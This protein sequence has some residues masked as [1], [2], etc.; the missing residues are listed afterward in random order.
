MAR[1]LNKK[2]IALIVGVPIACGAMGGG[3]Y[4]A[5]KMH[6]FQPSVATLEKN[7]DA[8]WASGDY[9]A[10]QDQYGRAA[11]RALTNIPLQIKFVDACDYCVN[12]DSDKYQQL[13][14][15]YAMIHSQDLRNVEVLRR[16][17]KMQISDVKNRTG[18]QAN[19]VALQQ[20][21]NNILA[22]IPNDR[23]ARKA[24]LIAVIEPMQRQ[25]VLKSDADRDAAFIDVDKL[26]EEDPNDGEIIFLK[27]RFLM[28]Q[29]SAAAMS[30][31][32]QQFKDMLE[33][34]RKFVDSAVAKSPENADAQFAAYHVYRAVWRTLAMENRENKDPNSEKRQ[35][36]VKLTMMADGFLEKAD[37]FAKPTMLQE[38]FINIRT[39]YIRVIELHDRKRADERYKQLLEE[40]PN[41][42]IPRIL[43]AKFLAQNPETI[44]E[45]ITLL[46]KPYKP[47]GPVKAIESMEL[48]GQEILET[49][50]LQV[51]RLTSLEVLNEESKR[52]AR[53]KEVE[54]AFSMLK[55][56]PNM[57]QVWMRRIEAGIAMQHDRV[58]DAVKNL[59]DALSLLSPDSPSSP[60]VELYN[61]ILIEDAIAQIRLG[62][63]GKARPRLIE[64]VRRD[65]LNIRAQV[66]LLDIYLRE[67]DAKAAQDQFNQLKVMIPRSP[68]ISQYEPMVLAL[69]PDQLEDKYKSMKEDTRENKVTKLRLAATIGGTRV[70]D[71]VRIGRELVAADPKDE[72][73]VRLLFGVLLVG[74][75]DR[76]A[77]KSVLDEAI[78]A[79]PT[80]TKI[81]DYRKQMDMAPDEQLKYMDQKFDEV[82]DPF[83]RAMLKATLYRDRNEFDKAIESAKE[84]QKL[85]PESVEALDA[86]FSTLVKMKKYSEADEM[87]ERFDKLGGD[88]AGNELRKIRLLVAKSNDQNSPE[89]R[90]A[91][92]AEATKMSG[93]AAQKY[94]NI[95]AVSL[96][97][98]Q[99]L[100]TSLQFNE[101]AEQYQQTLNSSPTNMEAVTGLIRCLV[102]ANRTQE[103]SKN[104]EDAIR[105]FPGNK[106][107]R[108]LKQDY[109][110]SFGDPEL[111][112]DEIQSTFKSNN[113]NLNE[114]IR[115]GSALNQM[116]KRKLTAKAENE[117]KQLFTREAR[118]WEQAVAKFPQELR[119]A[120]RLA[121]VK[122]TLGD[123][124]GAQSAM[125]AF[126][127]APGNEINPVGYEALAEL[128]QQSG[129]IDAAEKTL[130]DFV[131][132]STNPPT[133]TILKLS[134]LYVQSKKFA[135]ALS[136]L[137]LKKDDPQ[138]VLN[139]VELLI[140]TGKLD[141]ART[142]IDGELKKKETPELNLQRGFVELRAG[143]NSKAVQYL[144]KVL[145]VRP[146]D[147]SALFYR[148]QIMMNMLP[149]NMEAARDDLQ[150]ALQSEPNNIN[151][152]MGMADVQI[153]LN[154]RS[155]AIG[156]LEKAWTISNRTHKE[157]FMRLM[158]AYLDAI[159]VRTLDA[160]RLLDS[161]KD[162]TA[163]TGDPDVVLWSARLALATND[164]SKAVAAAQKA[165]QVSNGNPAIAKQ[166]FE[167]IYK[168]KKFDALLAESQPIIQKSPDLW[169]LHQ[170]RG[171]TYRAM[172]KKVDA[173]KAFDNALAVLVKNHDIGSM[174]TLCNSIA[175]A[176][177]IQEAIRRIDPIVGSDNDLRLLQA[178]LYSRSSNYE[179]T[180]DILER[181][182][183]DKSAISASLYRD[184]MNLLGTTCLQVYPKQTSEALKVYEE[185]LKDYPEDVLLLNNLSY[186]HILPGSGGTMEKALQ[187]SARA[188]ELSRLMPSTDMRVKYVE[189]TRGWVLY[190]SGKKT[191]GLELLQQASIRAK[192]PD[193]HVHL[194]E[195]Y[196]EQDELSQA[197][198]AL[199]D[200]GAVIAQLEQNRVDVDKEVRAKY[201]ELK[202]RAAIKRKS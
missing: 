190:K 82:K 93:I 185:L 157:V 137:D 92:L 1:K 155:A 46:N 125:E 86:E 136:V 139:R 95:A 145:K 151:L 88:P 177:G 76:E 52:Q 172:E 118:H 146:T 152:Y 166:Y 170:L 22:Q 130:K 56:Y 65:P 135:E 119:F 39:F 96:L 174:Y 4:V 164:T 121:A 16:M 102:A 9:A 81:A 196:L 159:P 2:V 11:S 128:Y 17:M 66:Q 168:A 101:A 72:E 51:I 140:A 24:K 20:T 74:K 79:N 98:A 25:F 64:L 61:E 34:A 109:E 126:I 112:L 7:G 143:D 132:K 202:E 186:V 169:W 171:M 108:I 110:I 28:H 40:M 142:L 189:D 32:Q 123:S 200:A 105:K 31:N 45:A 63:T 165:V 147:V 99:L 100:H 176:L 62:Q 49:L 83:D 75:N 117:A 71:A 18:N 113:E 129:K 57:P 37:Q 44:E 54:D 73:A 6:L 153:K 111:V 3:Y 163:L 77:A 48:R 175:E 15:Y 134:Y 179:K 42:R 84:A 201:E 104:I 133:S 162:N 67:R 120:I 106:E 183:A 19:I 161:I 23:E 144:D 167:L 198:K 150:I 160:Q 184:V 78:K 158:A 127:K 12:G 41:S 191:E 149:P 181:I 27:V 115:Y 97:N 14:L 38:S 91:M 194:A 87:V 21:A 124:A 70:D 10:A 68:L 13:R 182:R 180:I 116:G 199:K 53:L 55:T 178:T 197:D 148:A 43:Y 138:I 192:F 156:S 85:R 90:S 188:Y 26:Y 114:W 193:V 29:V 5:K 33:Q 131:A 103:A 58:S 69:F 59:D 89:A 60:E 47:Q 122:Q 195:I 94:K 36:I 173:G 141:E 80:N 154:D 35:E 30:G 107:L 187:H 8:A 50:R